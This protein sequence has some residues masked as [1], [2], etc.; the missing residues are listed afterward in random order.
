MLKRG[1]K[2]K[3]TYIHHSS[4]LVEL[5]FVNLLF[6][7]YRGNIPAIDLEKPL[8]VF[9][10]HAHGD[11]F[12]KKIFE[13]ASSH[14]RIQYILSDDIDEKKVPD[15]CKD[16]VLFVGAGEQ[17]TNRTFFQNNIEKKE[18]RIEI[19]TF[20]STDEG[21]AFWITCEGKT[22]YHAGDL[23]F[24]FWRGEAQAWNQEMERR[25]Y[26][27][28][29]KLNGRHANIAFLV[30]DPRQENDFYLGIN[31]F[32]KRVEVDHIIPMHCW[33]EYSIIQKMKFHS[34]AVAY[35]DRI[36]VIQQEGE[37]LE[38]SS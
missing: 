19:E 21:V 38:W 30:L 15:N 9:A 17:F 8:I 2:L 28:I 16:K 12:S 33:G 11:H 6:D 36:A 13:L 4:F 18:N 31:E 29:D 24:W 23:H 10:S 32:V 5:D 34:C 35:K 14:E 37:I 27:E 25:Y 26:E 22:I 1:N 20:Q 3:I 7:Y